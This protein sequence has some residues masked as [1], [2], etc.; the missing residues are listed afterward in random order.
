MIPGF[1]AEEV[2]ITRVENAAAAGTSE[3][4]TDVLD[5]AGWDGVVFVA[6]LGDV[7]ATSVLTLTA[8]TN[9]ANSDS[10]PT[11]VAVPGGA[12]TTFTAGASD[13]DNRLLV[14]DVLRPAQRFVFASL[15]RATANAAVDGI[16]AIQYLGRISPSIQPASVLALAK[17]G[18]I[19]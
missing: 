15:T 8:F 11:P 7:T 4:R 10:T 1:L 19:V 6:L 17:A 5:M 2:R 9:T 12:T 13:A 14:V 3:L 16:I 18:P